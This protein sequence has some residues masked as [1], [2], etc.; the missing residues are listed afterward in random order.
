MFSK[1]ETEYLKVLLKRELESFR[2]EGKTAS[3]DAAVRFLKA[4]HDY[5]HFLERLLEKIK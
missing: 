1:D 2:K 5:G 3:M 4:E